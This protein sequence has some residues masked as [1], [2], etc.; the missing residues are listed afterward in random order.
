MLQLHAR[1]C[2]QPKCPVPRCKELREMR[3]RQID[4]QEDA[5]RM[6]YK[7]MMM[8]Q[9]VRLPFQR[10]ACCPCKPE[11][12]PGA[13]CIAV[14]QPTA[15]LAYCLHADSPQTCSAAC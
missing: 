4:R 13:E 15:A 8:R 11:C 14:P 3:R 12:A 7:T 1:S 5:R 6:N 2:D 10:L 9:Q